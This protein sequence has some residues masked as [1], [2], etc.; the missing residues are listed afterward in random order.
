MSPEHPAGKSPLLGIAAQNEQ[1]MQHDRRLPR[2]LCPFTTPKPSALEMPGITREERL[3]GVV[4]MLKPQ[5]SE[6]PSWA[7]RL[8]NTFIRNN[9]PRKLFRLTPKSERQVNNTNTL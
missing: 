2:A 5:A 8:R 3:E 9:D 4:A 7:I 6:G 1:N